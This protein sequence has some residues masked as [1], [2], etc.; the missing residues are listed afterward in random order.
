VDPSKYWN[1]KTVVAEAIDSQP[2]S[3]VD[4]EGFSNN[5]ELLARYEKAD[6]GLL[7]AVF[8]GGADPNAKPF[9]RDMIL[10]WLHGEE[11]EGDG[12]I[13]D[14]QRLQ[15]MVAGATM[16]MWNMLRSNLQMRSDAS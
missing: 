10:H 12:I 8:A 15:D 5:E 4:W 3:Y 9:V 13:D 11:N 16:V 7:D 1:V 6:D 14:P 2:D